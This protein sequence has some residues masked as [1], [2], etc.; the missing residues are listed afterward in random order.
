MTPVG[1]HQESQHAAKSKTDARISTG[2]QPAKGSNP[3][4]VRRFG[5]AESKSICQI[6]SRKRAYISLL[7]KMTNVILAFP[8]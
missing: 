3:E 6:G 7:A 1:P 4:G 2:V 8:I 5:G